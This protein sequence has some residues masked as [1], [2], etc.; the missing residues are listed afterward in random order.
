VPTEEAV[1]RAGVDRDS[2][3]LVMTHHYLIDRA[4]LGELLRSPCPYI[5]LL[6]P[7]QRAED[8]LADLAGLGIE[9]SAEQRARLHAPAG[10]DIGGDGPEAIALSLVAEVM[11]AAE[12][13][14][15]GWLRDRKGPIHEPGSA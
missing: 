12:G 1:A 14:P 7:K 13:R 9:I 3:A 4:L 11:A 6:G 5:G 10:L 15:G 8:L 2:Y